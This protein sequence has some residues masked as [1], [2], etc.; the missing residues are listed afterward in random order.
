MRPFF[1]LALK[2][3]ENS[4]NNDWINDF[5]LPQTNKWRKKLHYLILPRLMN[6]IEIGFFYCEPYF[7]GRNLVI[8]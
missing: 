5:E 6:E 1:F 2:I 4:E 3:C 7:I 8:I